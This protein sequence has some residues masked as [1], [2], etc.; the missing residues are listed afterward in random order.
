[1]VSKGDPSRA[2]ALIFLTE[3]DS[4]FSLVNGE[5]DMG[6]K[7]HPSAA[8]N[9]DAKA[10]ALI[11]Q[12]REMPAANRA[13]PAF[14]S[15]LVTT[16][17]TEA[18]IIGEVEE[19]V[20]D[21]RGHTIARYFHI[22]DGRY[23]MEGNGHVALVSLAEAIQGNKVF[24]EMLS[25][26][27]VAEQLF[28]WLKRKFMRQYGLPS[29]VEF[30]TAQAA[31]KVQDTSIWTP[32]A[33]MEVEVA[34]PVGASEIRPISKV[35]IDE[36]ERELNLVAHSREHLPAMF[37][38]F[39]KKYQGLAAVVT[40]LRAEPERALEYAREEAERVTSILSIFSPA[41]LVPEIKCACRAKGSENIRTSV[42]VVISN[43]FDYF[44]TVDAVIDAP[45]LSTWRLPAKRVQEMREPLLDGISRLLTT[46]VI[47]EFE[48][49]VL[50]AV[51]LY[52]KVAFTA[53][54]IEKLIY[55]LTALESVMLKNPS[56]PIGQNL[57]ERLAVLTEKGLDRR[58]KVIGAV[59]AVYAIRSRYIHHGN[60]SSDLSAISDF[61]LIAWNAIWAIVVNAARFKT[62]E[63]FVSAID[64]H[65][66]GGA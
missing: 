23:G 57:A 20:L 29:F 49:S 38:D 18:D 3:I 44:R 58:K 43:T 41:M 66:L 47:S 31:K 25:R 63:N 59:K 22:G 2:G 32:I 19:S 54:P 50:T 37:Q 11:A 56:E 46:D 53:D 4:R 55:L 65:R 42:S 7:L 8:L 12:I 9:Y 51:L 34:F 35:Q 45:S 39:R 36:W 28:D 16:Q 62:K 1:M 17:V 21:H 61:M 27:F 13:S 64:D 40:N 15:E 14:P 33:N 48:G 30:L 52:S 24:Y 10:E 5:L 26:R 60:T 6:P